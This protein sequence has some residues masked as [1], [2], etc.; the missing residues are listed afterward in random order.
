M[1][2]DFFHQ[3]ATKQNISCKNKTDKFEFYFQEEDSVY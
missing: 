1:Q 2:I 3:A